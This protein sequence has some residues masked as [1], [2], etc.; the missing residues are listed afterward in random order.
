M[1]I[2]GTV[3]CANNYDY[4]ADFTVPSELTSPSSVTLDVTSSETIELEWTGGGAKD[5]GIMIYEVLFD[6]ADGNFAEPV[7]KQSS[8]LGAEMRLTLSHAMLNTIARKSSIKPG[9]TGDLKWT[10]TAS[11]GGVVQQ[12]ISSRTISVTRGEGIDNI[13][14]KLHLYGSATAATNE[15]EGRLFRATE[16]GIFVIYTSLVDGTA[17]FKSST[18]DDAYVFY[19]N[20]SLKLI[21]GDGELALS[22]TEAAKTARITVNFNT[23]SVTVDMISDVIMAWGVHNEGKL[24]GNNELSY[25]G[26]GIFQSLGVICDSFFYDWGWAEERYRFYATVNGMDCSWGRPSH[27]NGESRPNLDIAPKSQ[28][29]IAEF[30]DRG[31][32]SYLWKLA[33][34][35]EGTSFDMTIYTNS[36]DNLMYHEFSNFNSL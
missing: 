30:G 12:S 28:F 35:C 2:I 11:R 25:I 7:Y 21:E 4:T 3:G 8:D 27:I 17:T 19:A 20:E 10:L 24:F 9:Q 1:I 29:Q 5:G 31:D 26:G 33:D 22:A 34:K 23:L 15:T 32:W 16:E 36:D 18:A 6:V 13:P 14:E